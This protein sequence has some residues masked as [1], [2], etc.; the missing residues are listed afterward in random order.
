MG[1]SGCV[2]PREGQYS[3][4]C[5][6]V[7]R[8]RRPAAEPAESQSKNG[9]P[10]YSEFR[11]TL[12]LLF[13]DFWMLQP[14]RIR[15]SAC[16]QCSNRRGSAKVKMGL[17]PLAAEFKL[18]RELVAAGCTVMR[19]KMVDAPVLQYM[20]RPY[21]HAP[22]SVQAPPPARVSQPLPPPVCR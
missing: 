13:D 22:G 8:A 19:R 3:G 17:N 11:L 7:G 18:R 1:V 21:K 6:G 9:Y 16:R 2:V 20:A 14:M 15:V 4:I 12:V 10:G 5:A